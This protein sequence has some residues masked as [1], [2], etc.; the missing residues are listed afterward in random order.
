MMDFRLHP[1]RI[2]DRVRLRAE[3]II[4]ERKGEEVAAIVPVAHLRR[5]EEYARRRALTTLERMARE[6]FDPEADR[7]TDEE[8]AAVRKRAR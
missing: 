2:V 5:I 4:L 7:V 1:G 6:P 3:R 8:L